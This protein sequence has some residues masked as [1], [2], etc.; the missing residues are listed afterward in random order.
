MKKLLSI[1]LLVA[2]PVFG[3][4]SQAAQDLVVKSTE[5]LLKVLR[6]NQDKVAADSRYIE[7]LIEEYVVPNLDF[8]AMT[9]LAVAHHWRSATTEQKKK[10][11]G[12]FKQLLLRTYG[13]SLTEYSG[14]EI[15]F[16]P[17]RPGSKEDR[18]VVRSEFHTKNGQAVPVSFKLRDVDDSWKIYDIAID[19]ISLVTNYRTSFSTEIQKSGIDGLIASLQNKNQGQPSK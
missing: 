10:L 8:I 12:E 9:K 7:T 6:A 17:Y 16:L 1:L 18:A 2:L 3:Y 19:G 11:I 14:E 4:A 5:D 15:I 13:K